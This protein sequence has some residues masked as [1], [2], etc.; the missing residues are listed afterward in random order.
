MHEIIDKWIDTKDNIT[1]SPF[2]WSHL[3]RCITSYLHRIPLNFSDSYSTQ[4]TTGLPG[5]NTSTSRNCKPN[6]L[7]FLAYPFNGS[8]VK[9]YRHYISPQ[10]ILPSTTTHPSQE[11]QSFSNLKFSILSEQPSYTL[12]RDPSQHPQPWVHIGTVFHQFRQ[13]KLKLLAKTSQYLN[14]LKHAILFYQVTPSPTVPWM[15]VS[16][17]VSASTPYL[18]YSLIIPYGSCHQLLLS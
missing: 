15:N 1:P 8:N 12:A 14:L 17:L 4:T 7:K 13:V 2:H 11:V 9:L 16:T 6:V 5:S 10:S 18:P 3:H